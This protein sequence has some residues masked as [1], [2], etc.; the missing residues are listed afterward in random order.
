MPADVV[1][2][3]GF[4]VALALIVLGAVDLLW[5]VFALFRR[6]GRDKVALARIDEKPP[7]MLAV[8]I[9]AWREDA[10]IGAR[11]ELPALLGAPVFLLYADAADLD[12]ALEAGDAARYAWPDRYCSRLCTAS[13]PAA[14]PRGTRH[15]TGRFTPGRSNRQ[16]AQT[17]PFLIR[18]YAVG[19]FPQ[20]PHPLGL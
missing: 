2:W 20:F 1:Y 15:G 3:I 11:T 6:V 17:R 16:H 8:V 18:R 5:D 13:C 7:K 19:K 12:A 14:R 9:A 4:F 10:V